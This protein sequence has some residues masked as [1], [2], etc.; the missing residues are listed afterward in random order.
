MVSL[1]PGL[2]AQVAGFLTIQK[3]IR[4]WPVDHSDFSYVAA[5]THKD[6]DNMMIINT[7]TDN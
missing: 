3:T 6:T 7:Q 1:T 2:I 4:W 5:Q